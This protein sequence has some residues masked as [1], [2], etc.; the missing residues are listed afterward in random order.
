MHRARSSKWQN[1]HGPCHVDQK[2]SSYSPYRNL[3]GKPAAATPTHGPMLV[4]SRVNQILSLDM[5]NV[6][7]AKGSLAEP[8]A[9]EPLSFEVATPGCFRG[10]LH[11]VQGVSGTTNPPAAIEALALGKPPIPE[12]LRRYIQSV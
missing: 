4:G 10:L 11:A 6:D 1:I 12:F 9:T 2:R 8:V 7:T 5:T 3:T